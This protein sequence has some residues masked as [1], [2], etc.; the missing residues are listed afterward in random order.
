MGEKNNV[1]QT[2]FN[3]QFSREREGRE[4]RTLE[5]GISNFEGLCWRGFI[6]SSHFMGEEK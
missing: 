6:G 4:C 3:A 5:Q 1:Q 2:I